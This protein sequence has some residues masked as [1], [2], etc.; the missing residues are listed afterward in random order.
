M[1]VERFLADSAA[2]HPDKTALVV[3]DARVSFAELDATANR[4]AHALRAR[5]AGRGDRVVVFLDNSV[6]AVA[7]LFAVLKA[8]GVFSVVN[9]TT[10]ADKLAYVLNN[11]RAAAVVTSQRLLAAAGPAVGQAP[12]VRATVVAGAIGE[13]AVRGGVAWAD[14]LAGAP[15][16][17][18]PEPG[19]DIDLAMIIYTSGSTGF[20]KGVMMTHQNIDFAA[21]S[22]T[23]YLENTPDDIILSVLPLAFDYG[24][25]QVLMAAKLGMT[26]VLEQSFAFPAVVLQKLEAERATGFPVVPTIAALLLKMRD[27]TPGRFPHLRYLSNTAAALPPAHIRKLQELFPTTR[28][29]SMYGLTECK[30]CTYLPPDQLATRPGSVGK[31]IPGTEAYVVGDGG[32]RLGPGAVGELV[33]RGG[34]VMKGYWENPEATDRML[35]P[36]P[37]PWEK[38]LHTG[39]LFKADEEGFL[40]FVGR[41]DDIIKSRGEKVSPKE[42]ENV[43]YALPG[44]RE[45]AVVGVPDPVLGMALKAVIAPTDDAGLTAR[46]VVAHCAAHLEDFMVPRLVEFRAELPKTDTGKIRRGE[47]Q[48]EVLRDD[49]SA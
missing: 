26:V 12:S 43:L 19:V 4:L 32:E 11:C 18:P 10:K 49:G 6:E 7:A 5:G 21:T 22:I 23:T 34:H 28:V 38:V 16:D 42:V 46:D 27:L 15:A 35:R 9:P 29:F 36:G 8:G 37:Y 17:P 1:R 30:R 13:P 40:Y 48:A 33:I 31:A 44:V 3:G 47:V 39:D 2:R 24:L 14:A 45:A 41:K 20:P 25:Y